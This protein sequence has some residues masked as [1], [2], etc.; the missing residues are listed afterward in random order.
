M[1][2]MSTL[3]AL[4]LLGCALLFGRLPAVRG[5]A[6]SDAMER[7]AAAQR[8]AP[9]RAPCQVACVRQLRAELAARVS[10]HAAC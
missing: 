1:A 5:D 4:A 10:P 3:L 2:R 6:L 7:A 8:Y 9:S